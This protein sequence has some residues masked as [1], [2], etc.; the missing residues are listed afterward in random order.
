[1]FS[2]IAYQSL[3]KQWGDSSPLILPCIRFRDIVLHTAIAA[4]GG[5]AAI[6]APIMGPIAES[7]L[8]AFGDT[9]A[10]EIGTHVGFELGVKVDHT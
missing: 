2:S 5:T 8:G 3:L 1:V 7:A 10:V 9:I 6:A 4:T